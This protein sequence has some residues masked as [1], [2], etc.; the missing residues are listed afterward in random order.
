MPE[1]L[2]VVLSYN[3][4]ELTKQCLQSILKFQ[5][6]DNRFQVVV[7]DNASTDDSVQMLKKDFPNVKLIE[8]KENLGF[9]RGNNLALD[10]FEA[11]YYLFINSDTL[12]SDNSLSNLLDFAKENKERYAVV[13]CKLLNPDQSLQPN[14]GDLPTPTALFNW[15][16]GIDDLALKLGVKVPTFHQQDQGYYQGEKSVGWVSGTVFLI[17][18]DFINKVGEWDK[19][20]FMYAEDVDYCL[21]A[22]QNGFQVGWTEKAQVIHIGGASSHDPHFRQWL[23]EFKGLLYLY[24]KHYGLLAQIILRVFIYI[25]TLLRTFAFALKGNLNYSRT[26]AKILI[27]I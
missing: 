22:K 17:N 18:Q 9:S 13:S 6:K 11:E 24:Q 8:S 12:V 3:T 5:G 1:C 7:V 15:L 14:A 10:K 21:R 19:N 23:G 27:S 16:S 25:F 20:I 2:V 4:K 26:Y